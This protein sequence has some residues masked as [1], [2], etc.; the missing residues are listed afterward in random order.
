MTLL[1]A[2]NDFYTD[3]T[4]PCIGFSS[5]LCLTA[6]VG[7]KYVGSIFVTTLITVVLLAIFN[8]DQ[9]EEVCERMQRNHGKTETDVPTILSNQQILSPTEEQEDV[10]ENALAGIENSW[11]DGDQRDLIS[12]VKIEEEMLERGGGRSR[13]RNEGK[14]HESIAP[15]SLQSGVT[16]R[17]IRKLNTFTLGCG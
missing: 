15:E 16:E 4:F 2:A 17:V 3:L 1:S 10:E 6:L 7:E 11:L 9:N 13:R 12:T 8:D 5:V 14:S